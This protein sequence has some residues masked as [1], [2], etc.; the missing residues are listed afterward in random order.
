MEIILLIIIILDK[1]TL[2]LVPVPVLVGDLKALQKFNVSKNLCSSIS[3][4]S[5]SSIN[6]SVFNKVQWMSMDDW[7]VLVL[8][9]ARSWWGVIIMLVNQGGEEE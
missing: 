8:V 1:T 3:N 4:N 7:Y 2:M 9:V 5:N 6:D